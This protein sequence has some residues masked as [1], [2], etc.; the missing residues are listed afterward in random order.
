VRIHR[1]YI[2]NVERL[3][4]IESG[5]GDSRTAILQDGTRLPVSRSGYARLRS[6]L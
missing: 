6:L 4:R 2:L 3:A 1:S 5:S